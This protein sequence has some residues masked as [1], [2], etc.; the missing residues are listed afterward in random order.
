MLFAELLELEH[1]NL[2]SSSEAH[3]I[4]TFCLIK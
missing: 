1:I 4:T 3:K 2:T